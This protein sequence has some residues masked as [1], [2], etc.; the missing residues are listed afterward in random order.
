MGQCHVCWYQQRH[1]GKGLNYKSFKGTIGACSTRGAEILVLLYDTV[2]DL[3]M[4]ARMYDLGVQS[5]IFNRF[6][7]GSDTIVYVMCWCRVLK[8]GV[9]IFVWFVHGSSIGKNILC[10]LFQ[11]R[12]CLSFLIPVIGEVDTYFCGTPNYNK[13]SLGLKMFLCLFLHICVWMS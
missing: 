12:I 4:C 1:S 8:F 13:A 9:C 2:H 10:C 11:A 6:H 7:E 3:C 5:W